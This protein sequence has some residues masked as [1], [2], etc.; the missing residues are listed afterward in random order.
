MVHHRAICSL[1]LKRTK[2]AVSQWNTRGTSASLM[3]TDSPA[4]DKTRGS[5]GLCHFCWAFP[6]KLSKTGN[7]CLLTVTSYNRGCLMNLAELTLLLGTAKKYWKFWYIF[8][9]NALPGIDG[10]PVTTEHFED[11]LNFCSVEFWASHR[12]NKYSYWSANK[13]PDESTTSLTCQNSGLELKALLYKP[14]TWFPIAK[15]LPFCAELTSQRFSALYRTAK[16][17]HGG[18]W[19][20]MSCCHL[21][22]KV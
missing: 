5:H 3:I 7:F 4:Q 13:Q 11:D 17:S 22:W 20:K 1:V 6:K 16:L 8:F 14:L 2:G 15:L 10:N 12:Q 9:L 18:C 21:D 19:Q